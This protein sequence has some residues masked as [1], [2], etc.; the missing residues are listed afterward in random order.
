[1]RP[2]P[3]EISHAFV[4]HLGREESALHGALDVLRRVR[5]ALLRSDLKELI[6]LRGPQEQASDESAR[7]RAERDRLRT[8]LAA[9]FDLP[10]QR[11][12]V[13]TLTAVLPL[14]LRTPLRSAGDRL[15]RLA[16]E[17]DVLVRGNAALVSHLL[18]FTRRFL[19]D[20]T[21]GEEAAG[22]Y[23]AD[24]THLEASFGSLLSTRG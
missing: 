10:A 22:C 17:V 2:D 20:L 13:S 6:A 15:R 1:M 21:G 4:T 16:V 7:L 9:A 14:D 5:A 23:G 24:G 3:A 18:R 12:S 8:R 19:F 11:V